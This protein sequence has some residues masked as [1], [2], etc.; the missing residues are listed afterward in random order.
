MAVTPLVAAAVGTLMPKVLSQ[1]LSA[2]IAD[3]DD[4]AAADEYQP[5][6]LREML[7]DRLAG[8]VSQSFSQ[9]LLG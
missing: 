7:N 5:G 8:I 1:A 9:G 3:P 6:G 4:D 2:G